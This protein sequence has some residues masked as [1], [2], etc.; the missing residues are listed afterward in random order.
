[1]YLRKIEKNCQIIL[2]ENRSTRTTNYYYDIIKIRVNNKK[3][4]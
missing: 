2:E 1:M 3:Y 4:A